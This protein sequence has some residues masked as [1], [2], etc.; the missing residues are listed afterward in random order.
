MP[1]CSVTRSPSFQPNRRAR[2]SPTMQPVRS[3]RKAC[4]SSGG[5]HDFRIHPQVA[6]GLDRDCSEEVL[7]ILVDAAEPVRPG[8]V[9][10][11]PAMLLIASAWLV[12]IGKIIDVERIVTIRVDELACVA[13]SKPS[14]TA[15]SAAKR[16]TAIATL[17]HR[18]RR[19]ALA[20][21]R[22][23][24]HE[25]ENFIARYP[26]SPARRACP[27]RGAARCARAR[28]RADRASP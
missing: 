25:A 28:R 21:P 22:A 24:Q 23:L 20:A 17:E 5:E 7:R 9:A 12:G 3:S 6:L 2:P 26:T 10:A 1:T 16:N 14:S 8:E 15:R 11:R 18:Q 4:F 13:A 19:A 27:S